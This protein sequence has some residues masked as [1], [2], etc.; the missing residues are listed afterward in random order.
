MAILPDFSVCGYRAIERL[1]R[2]IREG[3]IAYKAIE[4][5][6]YKTVTI[7]QFCFATTKNWDVYKE[8]ERE[9]NVLQGLNYK[10]IPRYLAQFDFDNGLCLVQEYIDARPLSQPRSFRPEE[11]KIIAVK[12]LEILVYLQDKIPAIF[13]RDIRPENILVDNNIEVYLLDFGLASI[14]NNTTVLNNVMDE[15]LGFM[16]PEQIHDRKLTES[17]DLY[18]LGVT[19]ICLITQTK[20]KDIGNLVDV[21][22]NKIIF[23]EKASKFNLGFIKWL[24]K[25]VEPNPFDRYLNAKLALEALQPLYIFRT[26]EI[27]L[28]RS[29]LFFSVDCLKQKP[30]QKIIITNTV[31]E[32]ILQGKLSVAPHLGDPPHTPDAHSWIKISPQEFEGNEI[33]C[34]VTVDTSKLKSGR[35]YEREIILSSNAKQEKYSVKLEII[36]A[37]IDLN[38]TRLPYASISVSGLIAAAISGSILKWLL[39]LGIPE[40]VIL[41]ISVFIIWWLLLWVGLQKI[42][43]KFSNLQAWLTSLFFCSTI[44]CISIGCILGA[45]FV[46]TVAKEMSVILGMIIG[47]TIGF[48]IAF[49]IVSNLQIVI[50]KIKD[51][52]GNRKDNNIALVSSFLLSTILGIS[53]G[54]GIAIGFNSY[55]LLGS[56][57]SAI[58]LSAALVYPSLSAI[59]LKARYH[60]QESKN[61]IDF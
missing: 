22:N 39:Q 33:D 41:K 32:T 49:F 61:F 25:I 40:E 42:F 34:I 23:R 38:I 37:A 47:G 21:Y 1:D 3:I 8:I 13:H 55:L 43:Q 45:I 57:V 31:T 28:D 7:K 19:L 4:I 11:I 36:T 56:I 14:G 15:M 10:G 30:T 59:L 12:I 46:N 52:S 53:I 20:S 17:S 60:R 26:P 27:N 24:E 6:T 58:L 2:N 29:S 48:C 54:V 18:S 16:P 35:K 5:A 51:R 44:F 50:D 9:I